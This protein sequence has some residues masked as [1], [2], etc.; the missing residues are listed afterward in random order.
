MASPKIGV[1]ISLNSCL[2]QWVWCEAVRNLRAVHLISKV[3]GKRAI[4]FQIPPNLPD[5]AST[6]RPRSP[7]PDPQPLLPRPGPGPIRASRTLT[8]SHAHHQQGKPLLDVKDITIAV[9]RTKISAEVR[10]K[11][12]LK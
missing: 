8:P 1:L 9:K 11:N 12:N 4:P 10:L 7:V 3:A 2:H 5:P 6:L